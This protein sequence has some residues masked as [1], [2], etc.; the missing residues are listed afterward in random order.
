F[1]D[2]GLAVDLELR[3]AIVAEIRRFRPDLVITQSP[4]RRLSGRLGIYHPDHQVTGEATLQ[5][6]YPDARNPRAFRELLEQDLKPHI[7]NE[8]WITDPEMGEHFVEV[9]AAMVERK[10]E[11]ILAHQSQFGKPHQSAERPL[12]WMWEL[13][14]GIDQRG[15]VS[16]A[17]SFARMVDARVPERAAV[18]S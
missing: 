14:Q 15:G 5:A 11:A 1:P 12:D 13:M 10:I 16:Y 4:V 7:V 2:G 8:I 9:S 17:E 3:K 18:G 6:V